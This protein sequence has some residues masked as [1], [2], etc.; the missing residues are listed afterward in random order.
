MKFFLNMIVLLITITALSG[1]V[2]NQVD[3]KPRIIDSHIIIEN[4]RLNDWL[5]LE[6]VNYFKRKDSLLV[7]EARFKNLSSSN[8]NVAYKIDWIDENGFTQKS[9]LSRWIVSEVEGNR[10]FV[11]NGISPSVKVSDFEI[12]L[13]E[14]SSDDKNRKNSYH[15]EYQN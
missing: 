11:I 7:V 3:L 13:Q 14:A 5:E 1:C 12:R 4:S 9:I 8:K 6:K 10:S 15:S 2:Q